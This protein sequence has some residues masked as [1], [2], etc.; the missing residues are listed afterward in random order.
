MGKPNSN[1]YIE[2]VKEFEK[3]NAKTGKKQYIVPYLMS[4]HPGCDLDDAIEL[5]LY[6]KKIGHMPQQVQDFYPTPSTMATCMYYTGIDPRTMQPVYVAKE[7]REKAMQRA[8]MQF[9][10]RENYNLVHDALVKAGREDLIGH[11]PECLISPKR[12]QN[13]N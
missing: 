7:P 1:T 9:Q 6:L 13:K 4:S 8:L 11:S 5:A 2:F 12:K 10:K 3:E